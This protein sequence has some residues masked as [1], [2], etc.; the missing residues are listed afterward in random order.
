[1]EVNTGLFHFAFFMIL[2]SQG[3]A[4]VD[5]AS[6]R[7]TIPVLASKIPHVGLKATISCILFTV[8]NFIILNNIIILFTELM[9]VNKP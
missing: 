6:P 2:L 1:M 3:R 8:N 5:F 7:P 4:I 9:S